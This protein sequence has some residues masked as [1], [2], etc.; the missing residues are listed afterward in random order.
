MRKLLNLL[1][2]GALIGA[3]VIAYFHLPLDW[4]LVSTGLLALAFVLLNGKSGE[5]ET[6]LRVAAA[7]EAERILDAVG[8]AAFIYD[9]NFKVLAWNSFAEKLFHISREEIMGKK[10]EPKDAAKPSWER[11]TQVVFPSLAPSIIPL[12]KEGEPT[13]I[14]DLS[15]ANP[16]LE[17]RVTTSRIAW[18]MAEGGGA[19]LKVVRDRTGEAGALKEKSDFVTV[20]S[21]QLR[22]PITSIVWA[23]EALLRSDKIQGE[24]KEFAQNAYDSA[25]KLSAIVEDLLSI[26]RI[27]E[28]KFGYNFAPM[29]IVDFLTRTLQ[30]ALPQ[31]RRLGIRMFFD[32]PEAPLPPVYADESKLSLALGNILDNAVRYNVKDGEVTVRVKQGQG[33]FVEI[34]VR[35]TGIG[36]PQ[37]EIPRLFK[38]FYRASNALKFE[39]QGS[40]LGLYISQGIIQ[41][42]GGKMGVESEVDHGTVI[43]FTLP[44]DPSLIP[45]KESPIQ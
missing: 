2:L 15:F 4:F 44:T 27:E 41:A 9:S 12:S 16:E 43:S 29:D 7:P 31:A 13:Q 14:M 24:D 36:I 30:S 37:E 1:P 42:H 28:G 3:V 18:N 8:D 17:L 39:T 11:L 40:G 25:K 19:F 45:P 32:R 38:K 35:D 26:S 20:A 6:P 23:T 22:T 33:S 10:I 21:H 5:K 34:D